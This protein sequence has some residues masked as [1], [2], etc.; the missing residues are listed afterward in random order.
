MG[1]LLSAML[2]LALVS[3]AC[4][5]SADEL[6]KRARDADAAKKQR[7]HQAGLARAAKEKKEQEAAPAADKNA[8]ACPITA[9]R[10][11]ARMRSCGLNMDGITPVKLCA[12]LG[13]V[14]LNFVASRTCNEIEAIMFP[15]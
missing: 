13:Q 4:K 1:R 9:E 7:A 3:S 5:P 11:I 14:K 15:Q 8:E 10:M 6:A 12:T 2:A